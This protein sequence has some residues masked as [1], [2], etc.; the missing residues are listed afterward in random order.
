MADTI[1]NKPKSYIMYDQSGVA[2]DVPED[3]VAQN[4]RAGWKLESPDQAAERV[5]KEYLEK[6]KGG[7]GGALIA[8]GLGVARG[9]SMGLSDVALSEYV[10]PKELREYKEAQPTASTIGEVGAMVG[11]SVASI[12]KG[13]VGAGSKLLG[14]KA[15]QTAV[16]TLKPGSIVDDAAS[17]IGEQ[18]GKQAVKTATK[19]PLTGP[20]IATELGLAAER[21]IGKLL[22]ETAEQGLLKTIAKSGV[23]KS[24]GGATEAAFLS[25]GQV[26]SEQALGDPKMNADS[27]LMHIGLNALLGGGIAGTLGAISP[28]LKAGANKLVGSLPKSIE[29]VTAKTAL[30]SFSKS[31][32]AKATN[33]TATQI[34]NAWEQLEKRGVSKDEF[35]EFLLK[36]HDELGGNR[37]LDKLGS[38]QKNLSNIQLLVGNIGENISKTID[39]LDALA[40]QQNKGEG[41]LQASKIRAKLEKEIL[42]PMLLD[43]KIK[44]MHNAEYNKISN[45]LESWKQFETIPFKQ[46]VELK[47]D[48]QAVLSAGS[49]K[50]RILEKKA[51]SILKKE[52]ETI[53]NNID[54]TLGKAYQENNKKYMTAKYAE[55]LLKKGAD[56]IG[57][58]RFFSLTDYIAG[59]AGGVVGGPL[60]GVA[61]AQANK[62]ARERGSAVLAQ[63]ADDLANTAKIEQ[64]SQKGIAEVVNLSKQIISAKD[65]QRGRLVPM[66]NALDMLGGK[67]SKDKDI[68]A[69]FKRAYKKVETLAENP[70]V[71]QKTIEEKS[72]N[73]KNVAPETTAAMTARATGAI[74]YLMLNAPQPPQ[75][76]GYSIT[77]LINKDKWQPSNNEIA[78]WAKQVRAVMEPKTV[79]EDLKDGN[80]TMESVKAFQAVYP[81]MYAG[82]G[83]LLM[84]RAAELQEELPY[85]KRVELSKFFQVPV[86][87]TMTLSFRSWAQQNNVEIQKQL[88]EQR[89]KGKMANGE[90]VKAGQTMSATEKLSME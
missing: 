46:A 86:D 43:G 16:K 35:A 4:L 48:I 39:D 6:E 88:N 50:S 78:R 33:A 63:V 2:Y 64:I 8:G 44:P 54:E 59:G 29:N 22:G 56:R 75:Y 23:K 90:T 27:A 65:I 67:S 3:G 60:G 52:L 10:N 76:I 31:R 68:Q 34:K 26:I 11:P 62:L 57:G 49:D 79:I 41:F 58:N 21:G 87:P 55:E 80:L 73:M 13:I 30:K 53:A 37:I 51:A 24:V 85:E 66:I 19:I 5:R 69:S 1:Q 42:E 12:G 47:R 82:V 32:A 89:N 28:A 7:I 61:M 25:T 40:A 84:S 45:L 15:A 72:G 70:E 14:K 77:P 74:N 36:K 18:Y 71:L 20:S 9:L 38:P 83:S 17:I 81:E